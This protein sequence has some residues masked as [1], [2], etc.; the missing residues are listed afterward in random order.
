[1]TYI[2]HCKGK[3]CYESPGKAKAV[4]RA[5]NTRK[6]HKSAKG[7]AMANKTHARSGA[8]T[9]YHCDQCGYYHVASAKY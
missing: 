7:A 6:R 2:Q 5:I 1:M 9:H 8:V 4:V 3:E